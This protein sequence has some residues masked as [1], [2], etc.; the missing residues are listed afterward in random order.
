MR[1]RL[2]QKY[3]SYD[4]KN[5]IS[6]IITL[7]CDFRPRLPRT[8]IP[9]ST[10]TPCKR[11]QWKRPNNPGSDLLSMAKKIYIKRETIISFFQHKIQLDFFDSGSVRLLRLKIPTL[12]FAFLITSV[13]YSFQ[14]A[15][16]SP[17]S[18][19]LRLLRRL[20]HHC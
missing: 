9:S 18:Y 11:K 7:S 14:K 20:P 6:N 17:T 3:N 15:R 10:S 2:Y 12:S 4:F 16:R 13:D 19:S 8:A 1:L 5:I